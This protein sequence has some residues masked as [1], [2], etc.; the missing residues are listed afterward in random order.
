M[1]CSAWSHRVLSPRILSAPSKQWLACTVQLD[2]RQGT[3]SPCW[4]TLSFFKST[5]AGWLGEILLNPAGWGSLTTMHPTWVLHPHSL[6]D[7]SPI[8]PI[9][10][11]VFSLDERVQVQDNTFLF[12]VIG[13]DLFWECEIWARQDFSGLIKRILQVKKTCRHKMREREEMRKLSSCFHVNEWYRLTGAERLIVI[14][15][16]YDKFQWQVI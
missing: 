16:L 2:Y 3:N 8:P 6:R 1:A 9:N 11:R 15:G 10:T 14:S 12:G 7:P 13:T 4:S 5:S